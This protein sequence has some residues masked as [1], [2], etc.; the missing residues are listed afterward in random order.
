VIDGSAG[1]LV[2]LAL[3]YAPSWYD[4]SDPIR[5]GRINNWMAFAANEIHHSLL[6]VI[7][8]AFY[9]LCGYFSFLMPYWL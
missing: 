6:K 5:V 9:Y 8:V 4:V 2:Y 3:K 7:S 1:I